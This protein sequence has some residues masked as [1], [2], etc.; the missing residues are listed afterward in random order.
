[1]SLISVVNFN[2]PSVPSLQ[3]ERVLICP[4]AEL[5]HWKVSLCLSVDMLADSSDTGTDLARRNSPQIR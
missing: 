5:F 3:E 1:M 2:E 4:T